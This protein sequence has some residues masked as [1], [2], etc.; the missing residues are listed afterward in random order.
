MQPDEG[1]ERDSIPWIGWHFGKRFLHQHAIP[2]GGKNLRRFFLLLPLPLLVEWTN[3]LNGHCSKF[4][5]K[6]KK[7]IIVMAQQFQ[8]SLY[9]CPYLLWTSYSAGVNPF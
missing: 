8:P 3:Y 6:N 4:A 9:I 2:L 5:K 7:Q 1:Q